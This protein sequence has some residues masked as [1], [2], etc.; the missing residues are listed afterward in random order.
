VSPPSTKTNEILSRLVGQ[1]AAIRDLREKV[2]K[3]ARYDYPVLIT[4]ET[5]VGKTLV[6]ELIHELSERREKKF[7]HQSCSNISSELFESDLFGHE[8]GAF[9]GAVSRKIGKFEAADGGTLFLDE[10]ADLKLEN[11]AKLLLFLEGVK[12]SRVGGTEEISV[13]V[14]IIA[15]TNRDLSKIIK[16]GQ[17]RQDLYFRLAINEIHIPPLRERKEDIFLLVEK[18]LREENEKNKINKTISSEAMAILLKYDFPGNIRELENIIRRAII[19]SRGTDI[20]ERDMIFIKEYH[21][22]RRKRITY[23]QAKK[24]LEKCCQCQDKNVPI[25]VK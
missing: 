15:A 3:A 17:F 19:Y 12:F 25:M 6:A 2:K 14:R 9:T 1:S 8:R 16:A 4:G 11:Q 7:L 20:R 18:I 22:N 21:N 10:V 23:D 24:A 5:G 13:D